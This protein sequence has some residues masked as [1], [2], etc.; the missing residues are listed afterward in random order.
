MLS[1]LTS[2]GCDG[3]PGFV[4]DDACISLPNAV[5]RVNKDSKNG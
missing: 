2:S 3:R 4:T 5:P 1:T